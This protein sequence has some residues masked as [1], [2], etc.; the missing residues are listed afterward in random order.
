VKQIEIASTHFAHHKEIN[1]VNTQLEAI[2]D[3]DTKANLTSIALYKNDL[4]CKLLDAK[5]TVKRICNG[6]SSENGDE[7]SQKA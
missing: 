1:Q 6:N 7:T 2:I 4:E 3:N 5:E